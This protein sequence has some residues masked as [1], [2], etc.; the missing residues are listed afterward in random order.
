[1]APGESA[2]GREHFLEERFRSGF[3]DSRW[4]DRTEV[5]EQRDAPE[6][7]Q[8]P[9]AGQTQSLD[10][11]SSRP[12]WH[13]FLMMR[14]RLFQSCGSPCGASVAGNNHTVVRQNEEKALRRGARR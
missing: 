4:R 10:K 9:A 7:G 12:T 5:G 1:M 13:R 3:C 11:L 8:A 2:G 14:F 6:F